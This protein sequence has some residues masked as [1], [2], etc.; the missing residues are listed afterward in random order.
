MIAQPSGVDKSYKLMSTNNTKT[1]IH[2]NVLYAINY[3]GKKKDCHRCRKPISF[4]EAG[5]DLKLML[6][7]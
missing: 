1:H 6:I 4:R 5:T 2:I 3:S 7:E